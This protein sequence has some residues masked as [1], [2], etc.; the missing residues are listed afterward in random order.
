M[1]LV[2]YGFMTEVKQTIQA[3]SYHHIN[4][5][6]GSL[7][8][9]HSMGARPPGLHMSLIPGNLP[10]GA[11][12]AVRVGMAA[13]KEVKSGTSC[14]GETKEPPDGG[15]KGEGTFLPAY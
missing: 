13:S 11:S 14:C 10:A 7:F 1:A 5:V 15:V 6:P 2:L 4:H 8:T 9:D 3:G 12:S